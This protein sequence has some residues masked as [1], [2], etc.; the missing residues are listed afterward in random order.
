MLTTDHARRLLAAGALALGLMLAW[1]VIAAVPARAMAR[2]AATGDTVSLSITNGTSFTYGAPTAPQFQVVVVMPAPPSINRPWAVTVYVSSGQTFG[3]TLSSETADQ[4]T[5]TFTV[6]TTGAAIPVGETS[7]YA[8]FD[9]PPSNTPESSGSVTFTVTKANTSLKCSIENVGSMFAP[10]TAL[11]FYIGPAGWQNGTFTI[12]FTG[13]GAVTYANL[14][15]DSS[16]AVTAPGPTQIGRYDYSCLFSGTSTLASAQFN[17]S[18]QPLL[19]SEMH[20][21]GGAQIYTNPTTVNTIQATQLYVVM[22]GAPG[23]P[24]PTGY[25]GVAIGRYT[26]HAG[27]TLGSDGTALVT[28]GRLPDLSGATGIE[29]SYYGDPYYT[30]QTFTF[31][32][33]NPPIPG[34]SSSGNG[35][36][37]NGSKG[38]VV[39]PKATATARAT[40]GATATPSGGQ[41][42]A[43]P[44]PTAPGVRST[45]DILGVFGAPSW[46]NGALWVVAL[47]ILLNLGGGATAYVL[48]S[49]RTRPM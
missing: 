23:L 30:F 44:A 25:V 16:N 48:L 47:Y 15:A 10:G 39:Q 35:S 41:Y 27:I 32:L 4:L 26:T 19:I 28:L 29:L 13:P 38:T 9:N 45:P 43:A 42:T 5:Y 22:R 6:Y 7:A 11:T 12:T 8:T 40:S 20:A 24:A 2:H 36:S 37:G 33:T 18:G 46:S 49:R 21:V 34:A 31:P 3:G 1:S 17:T 14:H